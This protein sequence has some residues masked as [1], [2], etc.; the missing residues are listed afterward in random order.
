MNQK[1]PAFI[2]KIN[3]IASVGVKKTIEQ[4]LFTYKILHNSP[5][6]GKMTTF[7]L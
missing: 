4:M 6:V 2:S 3:A 7:D 5:E 1:N